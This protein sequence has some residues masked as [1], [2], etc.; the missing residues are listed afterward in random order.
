M[1]QECC[2]DWHERDGYSNAGESIP[3][4]SPPKHGVPRQPLAFYNLEKRLLGGRLQFGLMPRSGATCRKTLRRV[5]FGR[6]ALRQITFGRIAFGRIAGSGFC[7]RSGGRT[8]LGSRCK[9]RGPGLL[10][11]G[12]WCGSSAFCV[13]FTGGAN[14]FTG[15]IGL[16]RGGLSAEIAGAEPSKEQ[17][18]GKQ[19]YFFHNNGH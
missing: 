10:D 17:N 4:Q 9:Y 6:I 15:R 12:E 14:R 13:R 18:S 16:T 2:Y 8:G 5:A 1:R 3:F 19:Q 11:P 7:H